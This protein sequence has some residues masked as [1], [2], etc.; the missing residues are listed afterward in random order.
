MSSNESLSDPL[1]SLDAF[2]KKYWPGDT[3][4]ARLADE[5]P[6]I[7]EI[8]LAICNFAWVADRIVRTATSSPEARAPE[9]FKKV[10][11]A[12][13]SYILSLAVST[14]TAARTQVLETIHSMLLTLAHFPPDKGEHL[15]SD[16]EDAIAEI[17]KMVNGE[18]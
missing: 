7:R 14:F 10:S 5:T 3:E 13:A 9:K 17:C 12:A 15:T 2:M 8:A 6:V 18:S 1:N 11:D 16:S 4:A